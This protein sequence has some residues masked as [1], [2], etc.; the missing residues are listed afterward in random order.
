MNDGLIFRNYEPA[1]ESQWLRCRALSF[2]DSAY[3]DD[4]KTTKPVYENQSLELV[5][6]H[7]QQI[8]G[9]IDVEKETQ[10]GQLCASQSSTG[11]MIWTVGV[12]PE[13]RRQKI[14]NTLV[15]KTISWAKNDGV[16]YL[17]AWTRDDP[18]VLAWY[19]SLGFKRFHSYWHVYF[20]GELFSSPHQEV[21]PQVVFAHVSQDPKT[22]DPN[23]IQRAYQCVGYQLKL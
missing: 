15:E 20:K 21:S 2:L 1:D 11:A 13:Y 3:Y 12:T 16:A 14:A 4:V 8:A 22:F 23:Q 9:I 18:W 17:E 6:C 5:A 10:P 7:E 19:E